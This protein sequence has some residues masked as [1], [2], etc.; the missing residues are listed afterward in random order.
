V[1]DTKPRATGVG[2]GRERGANRPGWAEA[3]LAERSTDEGGEVRPKRPAG[4]KA[5][6]GM[7]CATAKHG[8]DIEPTN[9]VND[10]VADCTRAATVMRS[11]WATAAGLPVP[12]GEPRNRMREI[13]TSGSVGGAGGNPGSYPEPDDA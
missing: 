2:T 11:R 3:V 4:G 5:K 10:P 13:L 12:D 6:P 1:R 7:T 9:C 8:R